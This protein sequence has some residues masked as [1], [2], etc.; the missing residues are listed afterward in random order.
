MRK[1]TK[2]PV[3]QRTSWYV[4]LPYFLAEEYD[5]TRDSPV[6]YEREKDEIII[7]IGR[8]RQ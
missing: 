8:G 4:N 3:L 6:K 2:H 5:V 7:R 1:S